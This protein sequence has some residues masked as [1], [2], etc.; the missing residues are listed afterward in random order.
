[1]ISDVYV[2]AEGVARLWQDKIVHLVASSGL[3]IVVRG[4]DRIKPNLGETPE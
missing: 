4:A 2:P 3:T 1:L